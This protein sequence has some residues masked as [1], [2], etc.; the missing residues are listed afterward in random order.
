MGAPLDPNEDLETSDK[1]MHQMFQHMR[2][3][4][5]MTDLGDGRSIDEQFAESI[6]NQCFTIDIGQGEIEII[7]GGAN[8]PVTRENLESYIKMASMKLL[9]KA[10]VQMEHFL[11]GV[12]FVI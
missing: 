8:I 10:A 12:Y 7:P 2:N 6:Q 3:Y 11:S 4:A 9:Q 1:F 5:E